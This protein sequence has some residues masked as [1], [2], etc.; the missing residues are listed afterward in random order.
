[1]PVRNPSR[2]K[3]SGMQTHQS[4]N[5]PRAQDLQYISTFA[6]AVREAFPH[7]PVGAEQQ[8]AE[9]ACAKYSGRVGRSAAAK[10]LDAEMIR[11]AV[12]TT[13]ATSTLP[14]MT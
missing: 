10:T 12:L 2:T 3:K 11:R 6:A 8:I 13:F 1:M 4:R 7:C 5:A 9:H 14:T